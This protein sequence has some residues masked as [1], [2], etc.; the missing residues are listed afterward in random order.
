LPG[1]LIKWFLKTVTN[2]GLA[3]IADRLGNTRARVCTIIGYADEHGN[4]HFFE[5]SVSGEV[6]EPQGTSGFGWDHIFLPHGCDQT[7]AAMGLQKKNQISQRALA[8]SKLKKFFF[9][10]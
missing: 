7:F 5:G 6:V 3:R 4:Q 10:E 8:V 1:P 9:S 2:E